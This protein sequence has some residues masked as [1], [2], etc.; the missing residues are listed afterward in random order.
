M[1]NCL[2]GMIVREQSG[3]YWVEVPA[4]GGKVYQTRLRGKLMEDAQSADIAAIGDQVTIQP[5]T[6]E[7]QD[8]IGT[9]VEV[10][11]RRNML[12]RAVRTSGN[13]GAGN[14]ERQQVIMANAD[15]A[16]FVFAATHPNP[17][18]PL[19][20]RLLIT[21]ETSDIPALYIVV[22][23]LDLLPE[24]IGEQRFSDYTRMGYS[25]IYTSAKTG[26]G[27]EEIHT[28]LKDKVSVFTGPSGVG[29]SSLLNELQDGL[30]R[31]VK[32]VSETSS[33]GVHTTRDSALIKLDAGGYIADTPGIRNLT[34]WDIEPEELDGYFRDIAPFVPDCRFNDC[35]HS[36][37]P[38]CA[39]RRA[40]K[41]GHIS[42]RRYKH[43]LVLREELEEAIAIY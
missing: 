3:F 12:S 10:Q 2:N 22:N 13:R 34:V 15:Q 41:S 42:K 38:G 19:L 40:V 26:V 43:Y 39:V 29:K 5:S 7:D 37:E 14:H 9:I 24:G 1:E 18:L 8:N 35:T 27:L 4:E 31:S 20:D 33:E 11:E 23:K 28:L 6:N 32:S 16:L 25:V 17:N 21:G 30:G 36:N